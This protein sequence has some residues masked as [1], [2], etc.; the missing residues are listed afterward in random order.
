MLKQSSNE[1]CDSAKYRIEVHVYTDELLYLV[2]ELLDIHNLPADFKKCVPGLATKLL[3]MLTD[4][5]KTL[6]QT[7][8]QGIPLNGLRDQP[9]FLTFVPCWMCYAGGFNYCT[10]DSKEQK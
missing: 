3:V 1:P 8:F 10:D 4:H 2:D 7:W 5:V 9:S 6:A